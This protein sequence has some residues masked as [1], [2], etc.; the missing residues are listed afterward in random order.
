EQHPPRRWITP[1]DPPIA[2]VGHPTMWFTDQSWRGA[3]CS[4]SAASAAG[5]GRRVIA[6]QSVR[7]LAHRPAHR[8]A[9]ARRRDPDTPRRDPDTPRRALVHF[10]LAGVVMV[11]L[12]A[13]G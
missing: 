13:I 10:A 3:D 12:I 7:R 5:G 8:A 11:V 9:P 2:G 4:S 6:T 1:P